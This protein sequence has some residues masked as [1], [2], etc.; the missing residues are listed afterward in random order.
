M[1]VFRAD[2]QDTITFINDTAHAVIAR[3]LGAASKTVSASGKYVG[4][5]I[6]RIEVRVIVE[7]RADSAR[8]YTSVWPP[9]AEEFNDSVIVNW[10]P[11]TMA[12]ARFS[13]AFQ[14]GEGGWYRFQARALVF[15]GFRNAA[16]HADSTTMYGNSLCNVRRCGGVELIAMWQGES[17]ADDSVTQAAYR[18]R[19]QTLIGWFREDL[20]PNIPF[21]MVQIGGSRSDYNIDPYVTNVRSAQTEVDN[22]TNT[23]LA[24]ISIDLPMAPNNNWHY[25]KSGYNLIGARLANAI[26]FSLG[27][28]TVYRG[29][30]VASAQF[31][32]AARNEINVTLTHRGGSD[33]T[34]ATGIVGF[35]VLDNGKYAPIKTASRA[36]PNTIRLTLYNPATGPCG[37]RYKYGR[38]GSGENSVIDNSSLQLP[39]EPTT[40]IVPVSEPASIIVSL[41][42]GGENWLAGGQHAIVWSS[43]GQIVNVKIEY[44]ANNGTS[45]TTAAASAPN[46]GSYT[47]TLPA[48]AGSQY[49][50]RVS[51]A[52]D[53]SISGISA[54]PFTIAATSGTSSQITLSASNI[55]ESL[56]AGSVI[57]TFA[58]AAGGTGTFSL[59]TGTGGD[60]NAQFAIEG[61]SLKSASTFDFET[62]DNYSIRVRSSTGVEEIFI[63]RVRNTADAPIITSAVPAPGT[64]TC[65]LDSII[66]I[67]V[68]A[69]DQEHPASS[70][71]SA[72][73]LDGKPVTMPVAPDKD[74][75]HSLVYS[76][77]N[78]QTTPVTRSWTLSVNKRIL[79]ADVP[80]T[81][82]IPPSGLVHFQDAQQ[83]QIAV[84][85]TAGDFAYR[86]IK[87]TFLSR[88]SIPRSTYWPK[89]PAWFFGWDTSS[90]AIDSVGMTRFKLE[91]SIPNLMNAVLT[92]SNPTITIH[93]R[94][95]VLDTNGNATDT[96]AQ[97][98]RYMWWLSDTKV[99]TSLKY[100]ATDLAYIGKW[101]GYHNIRGAQIE[102]ER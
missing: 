63:I 30:F 45:W 55:D 70:L 58:L 1:F 29:P 93:H 49:S 74:G 47:W 83:T 72:W 86:P 82:S 102:C 40:S 92:I 56:P 67:A 88:A 51:K 28:A 85:F 76:V 69:T 95:A 38:A 21:F 54:A 81:I 99:D 16:K 36:S 60:N 4:P 27:N 68:S 75:Q 43:T 14:I 19:L 24:A 5:N 3:D 9:Y 96:S 77:T 52:D 42:K 13:A 8:V 50:V 89:E 18:T 91:P 37:V 59:V 62:R 57:G 84:Q 97:S 17:D 48:S 41:P 87:F 44:S 90:H 23:F 10:T 101:T 94:I 20:Q 46:T 71:V 64:I 34:P 2:A 33:F 26:A 6:N 66:S 32:S 25:T 35:D 80:A 11:A 78:G 12:N 73:T 22:G 7:K 61:T 79:A 39:L 15:W 53:V 98:K 31:A 100:L 65:S